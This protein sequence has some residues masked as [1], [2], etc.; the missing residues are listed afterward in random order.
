MNLLTEKAPWSSLAWTVTTYVFL[1]FLQGGGTGGTGLRDSAFTLVDISPSPPPGSALPTGIPPPAPF[2]SCA[3]LMS[4][5]PRAILRPPLASRRLRE[6]PA[7]VP[8]DRSFS[9]PFIQSRNKELTSLPVGYFSLAAIH[10]RTTPKARCLLSTSTYHHQNLFTLA[11]SKVRT[12]YS[13]PPIQLV[14][15]TV[16]EHLLWARH[17]AGSGNIKMIKT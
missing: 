5:G 2:T 15:Q 13:S 3:G 10:T 8:V 17:C 6:Q 11:A 16:L 7:H 4:F 14:Q 12:G 1:K 9:S